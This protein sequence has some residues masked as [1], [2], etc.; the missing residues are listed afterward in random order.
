MTSF[1]MKRN[2]GLT[3]V[4]IA[5]LKTQPTVFL[6]KNFNLSFKEYFENQTTKFTL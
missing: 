6:E 5:D 2:T 1:Y 4:T 3:W